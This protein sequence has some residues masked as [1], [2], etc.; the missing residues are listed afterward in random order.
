MTGPSGPDWDLYVKSATGGI[1]TSSAGDTTTENLSYTNAGTTALT[2][3][4]EVLVYTGT[5]A[6]PYNLALTYTTPTTGSS[7]TEGFNTGTKTAYTTGDVTFGSGLWTLNDALLGTSSSDPKNGL[8]SVRVRNSGKLGMKYNWATG[9]KTVTVKHAQ[10]GTDP[11]TTWSLWYSTNGGS[12]W[13]QTGSAVTSST[14]T[15]A[16]ATFTVNLNAPIRFEIR[17]TDG[18]ANRTNFDDFSVVGY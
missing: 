9:A 6:T 16:T 4:P 1:L 8:Q 14:T 7:F 12:T 5:S 17:K 18:T 10:Y 11:S 3:Y 2:I 13:L 15:L